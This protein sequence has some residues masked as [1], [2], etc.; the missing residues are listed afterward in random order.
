VIAIPQDCGPVVDAAPGC[1]RP[2]C[3]VL[4][5]SKT[6]PGTPGPPKRRIASCLQEVRVCNS[7]WATLLLR[8]QHRRLRKRSQLETVSIH[9]QRI[10][11]LEQ[12]KVATEH[13]LPLSISGMVLVN[14]F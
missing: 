5:R 2:E 12:T 1:Y 11:E 10:A 9:E 7:G 3:A 6:N 13:K 14:S 4:A 8:R